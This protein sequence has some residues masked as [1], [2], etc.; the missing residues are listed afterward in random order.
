MTPYL[1]RN[2]LGNLRITV[3][4]GVHCN[5]SGEIQ[6][7]S[8]LH[9]PQV[10]ALSLH[11]HRSGANVGRDHEG[12]ALIDKRHGERVWRGIGIR[13]GSLTLERIGISRIVLFNPRNDP[14]YI[15]APGASLPEE[16]WRLPQSVAGLVTQK[17]KPAELREA[18][19]AQPNEGQT[20][21]IANCLRLAKANWSSEG[22][23]EEEIKE[24]PTAGMTRRAE[25]PKN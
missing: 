20:L 12:C 3:T 14:N 4:E 8:V 16:H 11:H 24:G 18:H 25:N 13:E 23:L 5:T 17:K 1:L 15:P 10:A 22:Q 21:S 19:G 9:I 2:N 7:P 6:V